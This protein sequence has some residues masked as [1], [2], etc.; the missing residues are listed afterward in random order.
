MVMVDSLD[1]GLGMEVMGLEGS[2]MVLA[3]TTT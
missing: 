2:V 3:A 1:F